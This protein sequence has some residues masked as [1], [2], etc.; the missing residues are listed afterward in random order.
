MTTTTPFPQP[1]LSLEQVAKYINLSVKTVRRFVASGALKSYRLG[2][3]LRFKFADVEAFI[4][5]GADTPA[6]DSD[7]TE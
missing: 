2:A 7:R 1:L 5:S 6:S 3:S 4:E